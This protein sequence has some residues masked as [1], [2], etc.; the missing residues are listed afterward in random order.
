VTPSDPRRISRHEQAKC[1]LIEIY[2]Y[3]SQRSERAARKF[4]E[5]TRTAFD[6]IL[7]VPGIGRRWESPLTEL[8]ELR[9]TSVSRRFHDYL[10]FY[11]PVSDGVQIVTVL[12]GARDIPPLIDTLSL[13]NESG[14][15]DEIE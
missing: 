15:D 1:D 7:R 9:V 2:A 8:R 6:L 14:D 12:H 5:E 10:I 13:E 11:R 3:L 4:L